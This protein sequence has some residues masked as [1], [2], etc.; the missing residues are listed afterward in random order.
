LTKGA[1]TILLVFT[2]HSGHK[3]GL[4][5]VHKG[6]VLQVLGT[7][8]NLAGIDAKPKLVDLCV[9]TIIYLTETCTA[10]LKYGFII[11]QTDRV[12]KTST[13]TWRDAHG[14]AQAIFDFG[15]AMPGTFN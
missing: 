11:H 1:G 9:E 7:V 6:R 3:K 4:S 2:L 12:A 14:V 13:S 15:F 5:I 8:A 10:D